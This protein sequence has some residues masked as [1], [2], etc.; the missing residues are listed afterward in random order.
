MVEYMGNYLYYCYRIVF[1]CVVR[2]FF[3]KVYFVNCE[4]RKLS[5]DDGR[6]VYD[7]L[8]E[9]PR[10]ENGF[11]NGCNGKTYDEFKKMVN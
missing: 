4:L 11:I 3:C 2:F 8:Q 6:D 7:M 1:K 10:E 5:P 9:L